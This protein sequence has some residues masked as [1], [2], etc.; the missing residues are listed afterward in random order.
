ME[1]STIS[2]RS[3]PGAHPARTGQRLS[4]L[5]AGINI[6]LALVKGIAGY[7][8]HSHA[9]LADAVDSLV[10][11]GS[12]F[13]VWF[14]LGVAAKPPDE[15]HPYGHGK[16]EPIAATI[17]SLLLLSAGVSI[18]VD[19]V[20]EIAHPQHVPKA[21]T[22]LVL[23]A[24]I[25]VKLALSRAVQRTGDAIGSSALSGE[26]AHHRADAMTSIA[27]FL[28][29]AIALL[30]GEHFA[31]ADDIA[32]L[33]VSGVIFMNAW[34]ILRSALDELSDAAPPP[35]IEQLVRVTALRVTGV[36][37]LDKCLVRKMGF[38]Y[39]VDL[40]VVVDGDLPVREGHRIAHEVKDLIRAQRGR[41]TEVLV[42][43]EPDS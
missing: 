32:A 29:I 28:G 26:A 2:S 23:I 8:G 33:F 30:G 13:V 43:I 10:D 6:V 5:G 4:L 3:D 16:A 14:G 17:V 41:I 1:D 15:N 35:E 11:A 20:G 34:Q 21:F 37:G 24:V 19:S 25:V 27:A 42:H 40:H 12:S 31:R 18:A 36:R 22:L 7:Y 39:L 38:D 9:L